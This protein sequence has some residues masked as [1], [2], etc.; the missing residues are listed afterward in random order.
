MKNQWKKFQKLEKK[1]SPYMHP[2]CA[3]YT[4][5]MQPIWRTYLA[6]ARAPGPRR[7]GASGPYPQKRVK[8]FPHARAPA[9]RVPKSISLFDDACIKG[10]FFLPL[11][12]KEGLIHSFIEKMRDFMHFF[13]K[14]TGWRLLLPLVGGKKNPW[15]KKSIPTINNGTK[16]VF[17][18][19]V[20]GKENG[21]VWWIFRIFTY[22]G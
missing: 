6:R 11:E 1:N 5:Y 16:N 3:L 12:A 10:F 18:M 9:N 14:I 8:L 15:C 20:K 22:F 13:K 17:F 4:P 2:I 21:Y 19:F 7:R